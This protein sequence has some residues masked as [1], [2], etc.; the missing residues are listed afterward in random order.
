M[1]FATLSMAYASF[2]SSSGAGAVAPGPLPCRVRK[3]VCAS[4]QRA[5]CM[6]REPTSASASGSP[7]RA[8]SAACASSIAAVRSPRARAAR[9]AR[10]RV[11]ARGAPARAG[12][13]ARARGAAGP[14]GGRAAEAVREAGVRGVQ[15]A[16]AA[17]GGQEHAR[18]AVH[19]RG[20]VRRDGRPRGCGPGAVEHGHAQ[21]GAGAAPL[22]RH[23]GGAAVPRGGAA[24]P[25]DV[26]AAVLGGEPD[27]A[28]GGHPAPD[29]AERVD[30]GAG[31]GRHA[32]SHRAGDTHRR[33]GAGERA[34]RQHGARRGAAGARA[35]PGAG[36]GGGAPAVQAQ[37]EEPQLRQDDSICVA[38]AA[39]G[40]A[41]AG[42]RTVC[43]ARGD[44]CS[45]GA[46]G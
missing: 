34:P 22:Q 8:A 44:P 17:P 38:Q 12:D 23:E 39:S 4:D 6:C 37:E 3:A 7:G 40:R 20:R 9:A 29:G 14:T 1:M 18:G 5:A 15:D 32:A 13:D 46:P 21:P 28:G 26:G 42:A 45:T 19:A 16:T 31:P 11:P 43:E 30:A 41:L 25:R 36:A 33:G 24:V 35:H 27:D 2:R 10:A